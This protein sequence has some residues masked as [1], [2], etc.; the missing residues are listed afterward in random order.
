MEQVSPSISIDELE[1]L[2]LGIRA[3]HK[4]LSPAGESKVVFCDAAFAD[5][6]TTTNLSAILQQYGLGNIRSL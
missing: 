6:V 1:P 5:D 2:A 4:A 3:W